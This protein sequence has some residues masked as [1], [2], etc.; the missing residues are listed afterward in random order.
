MEEILIILG[1]LLC[2]TEAGRGGREFEAIVVGCICK[3][4]LIF[5]EVRVLGSIGNGL[6]I[7]E[8]ELECRGDG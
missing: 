7:F 5:A 2:L 8:T 3:G 4:V 6:T 1:L